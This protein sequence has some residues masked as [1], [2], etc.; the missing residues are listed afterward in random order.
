MISGGFG[1][2]VD[3]LQRSRQ[4]KVRT[5]I[6]V[7]ESGTSEALCE[8]HRAQSLAAIQLRLMAGDSA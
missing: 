7:M 4:R 2:F 5:S 6:P 8:T 1:D 3:Q